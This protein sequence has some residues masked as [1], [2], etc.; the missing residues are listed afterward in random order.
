MFNTV[1]NFIEELGML[2]EDK[3]Y[4][5]THPCTWTGSGSSEEGEVS[6]EKEIKKEYSLRSAFSNENETGAE[7]SRRLRRN[8]L[9]TFS[10]ANI[11]FDAVDE[12]EETL[13]KGIEILG[14]NVEYLKALESI[15]SDKEYEA[16]IKAIEK[17]NDPEISNEDK[18]DVIDDL[19]NIQFNFTISDLFKMNQSAGDNDDKNDSNNTPGSGGGSGTTSKKT[20]TQTKAKTESKSKPPVKAPA[21]SKTKEKLNLKEAIEQTPLGGKLFEHVDP[22]PVSN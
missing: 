15:L 22:V 10:G 4:K 2:V 20:A 11:D 5:A 3:A 7:R 12:D 19:S 16:M 13:E 18:L 21:A 9:N 14:N 6:E 8:I 17:L 1:F